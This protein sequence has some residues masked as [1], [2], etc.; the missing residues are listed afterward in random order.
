M[1]R[2]RKNDTHQEVPPIP[3]AGCIAR[4]RGSRGEA[5]LPWGHVVMENRHGLAVAGLLSKATGTAER[6]ASEAMLP[7]I[8]DAGWPA[9]ASRW[10]RTKPTAAKAIEWLDEWI[11]S[12]PVGSLDSIEWKKADTGYAAGDPGIGIHAAQEMAKALMEWKAH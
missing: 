11:E 10:A 1:A 4:W 9:V 6:R 5:V 3:T 12:N 2:T 8:L 7:R